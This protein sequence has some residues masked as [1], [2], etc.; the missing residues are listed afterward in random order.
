MIYILGS[1]VLSVFGCTGMWIALRGHPRGASYWL[2]ATQPPACAY[3]IW[4]RQYGF[5]LLGAVQVAMAFSTLARVRD[6]NQ[7]T[8]TPSDDRGRGPIQ[9]VHD[10]T[11]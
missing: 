8:Q 9:L 3:D 1:A 2:L 4:T 5:L 6:G 7:P 10:E 11:A